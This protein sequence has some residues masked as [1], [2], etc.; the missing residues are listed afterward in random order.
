MTTTS[1]QTKTTQESEEFHYLHAVQS[2][3]DRFQIAVCAKEI[4]SVD[5]TLNQAR[6]ARPAV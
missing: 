1:V 6:V 2:N 5:V 3:K 4:S